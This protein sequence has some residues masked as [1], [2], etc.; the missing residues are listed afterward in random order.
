MPVNLSRDYWSLLPAQ[1]VDQVSVVNIVFDSET[2]MRPS[3]T[4]VS[5]QNVQLSPCAWRGGARPGSRVTSPAL[6]F[7]VLASYVIIA[8]AT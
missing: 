3:I 7:P 4:R 1:L 6:A 2:R 8:H 5:L